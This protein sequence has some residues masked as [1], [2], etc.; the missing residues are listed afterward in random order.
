MRGIYHMYLCPL[1]ELSPSPLKYGITKKQGIFS[2][3]KGEDIGRN[4]VANS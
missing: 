3:L 1:S 2:F 4:K